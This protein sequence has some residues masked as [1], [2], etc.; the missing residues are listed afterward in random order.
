[1]RT[2]TCSSPAD[3]PTPTG[4][5]AQKEQEAEVG[6]I[7]VVS[8]CPERRLVMRAANQQ[9]GRRKLNRGRAGG[10]RRDND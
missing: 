9:R 2:H 3:S 10:G 1:M 8:G 5:G 4:D 6:G 7:P